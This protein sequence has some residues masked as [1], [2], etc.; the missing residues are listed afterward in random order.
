MKYK[1]LSHVRLFE[2]PWTA[3]EFHGLHGPWGPP[4]Q[5]TGVD[6][7]SLLQGISPPRSPTLQADYLPA[8]PQ[9]KLV[10]MYKCI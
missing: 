4:G 10:S 9:G 7:L 2:T 3:W 8:E 6:S 1:L 5:N